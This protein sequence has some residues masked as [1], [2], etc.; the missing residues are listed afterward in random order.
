MTPARLGAATVLLLVSLTGCIASNVVA[1]EDRQ[2]STPLAEL[3]FVPAPGLQFDGLYESVD[4]T[5]D[6]AVS[7]RRVFYLFRPDGSYTAAALVE[8]PDGASFQTLDG[9]WSSD[10]RGLVLDGGDPVPLERADD[11]VRLSAPNGAL[12]LR[13]SALQ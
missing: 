10:A 5:G 4:V 1:K 13:R 2:V 3:Q 6:A 8:G 9:T 12:V 11:H 7:L